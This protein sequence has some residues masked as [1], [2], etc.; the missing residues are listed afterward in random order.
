LFKSNFNLPHKIKIRKERSFGGE[1]FSAQIRITS[2]E[3][4]SDLIKHGCFPNKTFT[5][6]FPN[7]NQK[8]IHHFMRGYFDGDGSI[9]N[10]QQK[11][12]YILGNYDFLKEYQ[13]NIN[14]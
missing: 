1:F 6:R 8:L 2:K 5:L 7:I 13:K 12:W 4:V 9:Y 14:K 11:N 3:M 10:G